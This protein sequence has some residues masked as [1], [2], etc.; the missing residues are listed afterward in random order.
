MAGPWSLQLPA[1][2]YR[3]R[4]WR[5]SYSFDSHESNPL[6]IPPT[7]DDWVFEVRA[8]ETS[9]FEFESALGAQVELTISAKGNEDVESYARPVLVDASGAETAL[10]RIE[11][12]LHSNT[13]GITATWTIGESQRSLRMPAGRYQ[14]RCK[15]RPSGREIRRTVTL[16]D[17]ETLRLTL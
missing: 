16:L 10:C 8:G 4:P 13:V 5:S 2:R 7:G 12:R 11:H 15:V 3:L 9:E 1:G 17:G 6:P 14:L